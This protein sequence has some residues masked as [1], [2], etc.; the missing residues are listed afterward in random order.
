MSLVN[1]RTKNDMSHPSNIKYKSSRDLL[2]KTSGRLDAVLPVCEVFFCVNVCIH[3]I[4]ILH[5]AG[6]KTCW[7]MLLGCKSVTRTLLVTKGTVDVYNAKVAGGNL[8]LSDEKCETC[9]C[10][11]GENLVPVP[12]VVVFFV[13]RERIFWSR[14]WIISVPNRTSLRSFGNM[15]YIEDM[16][17]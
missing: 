1:N 14:R 11:L 12:T 3:F 13:A 16:F 6:Y 7:I 15:Y 10:S 5:S 8:Y 17:W 4:C 9:G 2:R